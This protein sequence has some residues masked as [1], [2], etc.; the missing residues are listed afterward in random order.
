MTSPTSFLHSLLNAAIGAVHPA[1]ALARHLP[2]DR[3][4]RAIVIGAGK[5]AASMAAAFEAAWEGPVEG[6]V[7]TRYGHRVPCQHIEVVEAAHP[8]PDKAGLQATERILQRVSKLSPQDTVFFLLSGGASSLLTRPAPGITLEHKQL[9]NKALLKSGAAIE[10][11]NCVRKHLSAIKGGRLALAC[12]PAR[13]FTFAI[14]DVVG[15]TPSV[16]GSGPSVAD[17]STREQ[18]LTILRDY[19]VNT[20]TEVEAWLNSPQAETPKPSELPP[21]TTPYVV[22]ATAQDALSAAA[23]CARSQGVAPLILGDNLEGEAREVAKVHAAIAKYIAKNGAPLK[24]PCV[25]LS[26][27]ETTVTVAG[28]GRGGRNTEFML[29]LVQ[30]LLGQSEIYALAADTDGIDGSEDNAGALMMPE[31]YAKAMQLNLRPEELLANND[32]YSYFE[33]LDRLIMTGPTLTNVNDFR[34]VLIA[35]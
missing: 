7:I 11:I 30:T 13:V 4:G 27:G 15:D 32:S 35:Q 22:I 8:V 26:G 6:T 19:K 1:H 24:P 21:D 29:G 2:A 20:P 14:S 3:S 16:I 31:D 5:A 23:D 28:R 25:L 17:T 10:E 34:A 33:A 12:R 18:A 9:I